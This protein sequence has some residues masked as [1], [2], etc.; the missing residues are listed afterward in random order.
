MII[1]TPTKFAFFVFLGNCNFY[2]RTWGSRN[3][4]FQASTLTASAKATA[5][6]AARR[7]TV[8]TASFMFIFD[9]VIG[10]WKSRHYKQGVYNLLN[11]RGSFLNRQ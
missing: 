4:R 3:F 1:I 2:G 11:E 6:M 5:A 7:A 10:F 8:K 9:V